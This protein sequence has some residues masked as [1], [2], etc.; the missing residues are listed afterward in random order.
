MRRITTSSLSNQSLA[1]A[2]LCHTYTADADR[3]LFIRLFADQ[4]A[5]NGAYSAYVTIQRS[6]AGSAYEVQPRAS[7]TVASGITA[8]GFTTIAIPVLNTDVVKVYLLGLAGDTTTPDIVTEIWEDDALRPVTQG[9]H[10]VDVDASGGVEVGS[11]QAGAITAAAIATDAIDADAIADNAI[12]AGAIAAGAI[13]NAKFA[14]G[15]IDSVVAP[16][17]DA[18]VSSRSSHSAAD[19]WAAATRTITGGTITTNSDKTGYALSAGGVQAI[20]DALTSALTTAGSIGKLLVDN[21]NATIS[22]RSSHSAAD[23]WANVTR[24]L[25]SGGG[26]SAAD[27]W[28]HLMSAITA[29]DGS[30]GGFIEHR[31]DAAVSSIIAAV[32]L[33]VTS[34][35]NNVS[36]STVTARRGDK[37]DL[38][39]TTNSF[40][41]S[42]GDKLDLIIKPRNFKDVADTDAELWVRK[43]GGGDASDGLQVLKGTA[44]SGVALAKASLSQTAV[45]LVRVI[46]NG[47]IYA[48]MEPENRRFELQH[49]PTGTSDPVTVAEGDWVVSAD[50]VRA[51]S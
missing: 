14:A 29:N 48:Q 9:Q 44:Q 11:F 10:N 3:L 41:F 32:T 50:V 1:T 42:T 25:T 51:T 46:V 13:T 17:L 2:L 15:A 38:T 16:N 49:T 7:S 22:S 30:I 6:G 4:V 20:W 5:G 24:T 18:A 36:G 21:V 19:V 26:A 47:D 45:T 27:I 37:V 43:T 34:I 23:V 28:N 35:T 8:I 31:L 39:L 40:V 33:G 12:N